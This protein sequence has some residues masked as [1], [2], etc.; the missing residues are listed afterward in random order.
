[1][2]AIKGNKGISDIPVGNQHHLFIGRGVLSSQVLTT[3]A[4][5]GR[6][7]SSLLAVL[8]FD[9]SGIY[10]ARVLVSEFQIIKLRLGSAK[11]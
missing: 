4:S 7:A 3:T 10:R 1:M 8:A 11:C 5:R 2:V 6:G 9:P